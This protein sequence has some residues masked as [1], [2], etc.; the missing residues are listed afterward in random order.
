VNHLLLA[1]TVLVENSLLLVTVD[2]P[3]QH[4]KE[5][6]DMELIDMNAASKVSVTR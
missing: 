2:L 3:R 1:S 5:A 4:A 6:V